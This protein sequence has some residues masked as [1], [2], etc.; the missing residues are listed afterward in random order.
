MGYGCHGKVFIPDDNGLSHL[1]WHNQVVGAGELHWNRTSLYRHPHIAMSTRSPCHSDRSITMSTIHPDDSNVTKTTTILCTA[2]PTFELHIW[3]NPWHHIDS[4]IPS[5]L[6]SFVPDYK[7][8]YYTRSDSKLQRT[9]VSK[10]CWFLDNRIGF[11]QRPRRLVASWHASD[12]R[13]LPIVVKFQLT[14]RNSERTHFESNPHTFCRILFVTERNAL[15]CYS[16]RTRMAY[17]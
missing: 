1:P 11:R 8:L 15:R 2:L 13:T 17:F 7:C 4:T 3:E 5:D 6:I 10:D 16:H 12:L 9:T 14:G